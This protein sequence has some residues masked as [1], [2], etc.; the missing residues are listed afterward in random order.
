MS[1]SVSQSG[2]IT[3]RRKALCV[4]G[5]PAFLSPD[6]LHPYS[7]LY[8]LLLLLPHR[9]MHLKPPTPVTAACSLYTAAVHLSHMLCHLSQHPP[10]RPPSLRAG[11]T[12]SAW[13]TPPTASRRGQQDPPES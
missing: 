6:A 12:W 10:G 9:L 5:R 11:R 7:P 3:H 2:N 1:Q 8:S 13:P 4:V